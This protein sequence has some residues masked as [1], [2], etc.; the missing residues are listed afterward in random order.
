MLQTLCIAWYL[1]LAML[2]INTDYE[3]CWST[4]CMAKAMYSWKIGPNCKIR[5]KRKI[6]LLVIVDLST[7]HIFA[8]TLGD[9]AHGTLAVQSLRDTP[10]PPWKEHEGVPA[11]PVFSRFS[12]C[13]HFWVWKF[14][15]EVGFRLKCIN[16]SKVCLWSGFSFQLQ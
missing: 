14:T 16:D 8:R 6:N 15:S 7:Y 3:S 9:D 13:L 10:Y 4:S 1:R 12:V 2:A 11:C 5:W